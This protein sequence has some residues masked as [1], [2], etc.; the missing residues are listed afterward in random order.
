MSTNH[1]MTGFQG[2]PPSK[3]GF[4]CKPDMPPHINILFRARPPLEFVPRPLK[5]KCRSFEGVVGNF[6]ILEMFEKKQNEI[7]RIETPETKRFISIV[8]NLEK[9]KSENKEKIKQCKYLISN[10]LV[11]DIPPFFVLFS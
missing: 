3:L 10:I 1:F 4:V 7:Q 5:G 8:E 9:H 6:D 11:R 2:M